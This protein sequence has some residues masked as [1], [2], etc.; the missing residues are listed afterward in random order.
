M[1]EKM[2][3]FYLNDFKDEL[4][5]SLEKKITIGEFLYKY[6]KLVDITTSF[7]V[8]F[9]KEKERYGNKLGY[10]SDIVVTS[11][12]NLS[13]YWDNI[14]IEFRTLYSKSFK[15]RKRAESSLVLYVYGSKYDKWNPNDECDVPDNDYFDL[16]SVFND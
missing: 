14:V 15:K 4:F 8:V 9:Y 2:N 10:D 7:R 16:L 12:S 3:K 6:R 11:Y 5:K 1:V 13:D